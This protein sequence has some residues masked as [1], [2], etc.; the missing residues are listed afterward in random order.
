MKPYSAFLV[1]IRTSF[2]GKIIAYFIDSKF[3]STKGMSCEINGE[4]YSG[5]LTNKSFVYFFVDNHLIK[6]HW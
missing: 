2:G 6:R 4:T 3:E 5:K 1:I